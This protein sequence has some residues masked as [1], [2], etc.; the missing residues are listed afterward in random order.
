VI[1]LAVA[2]IAVMVLARAVA[3]RSDGAAPAPVWAARWVTVAV[4]VVTV[5]AASGAVVQVVRIG[6]SGA[7]ASWSDVGSS[8][9]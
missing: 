3:R 2:T 7:K 9:G 5:V 4:A 6:H 1:V 8:Q